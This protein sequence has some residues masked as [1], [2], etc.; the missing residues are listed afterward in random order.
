M[1]TT[2]VAYK[3]RGAAGSHA[4]WLVVPA[5]CLVGH[6]PAGRADRW[7]IA[8]AA[9]GAFAPQVESVLS[10]GAGRT[11]G[12]SRSPRATL[13]A[14]DFAGLGSTALQVVVHDSTRPGRDRPGRTARPRPGH[15]RAAGRSPHQHGRRAAAAV[16]ASRGTAA[17]RS[18][19]PVP[20]STRTRWSARPRT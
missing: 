11:A 3:D 9:F 19:R 13:I 14:K 4:G 20:P 5:G 18:C 6:A 8:V 16:R 17:R 7:L 10:G 12:A 1:S 2:R 15:G